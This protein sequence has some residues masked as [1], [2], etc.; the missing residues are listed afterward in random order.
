MDPRT[1][2]P[3]IGILA[4]EDSWYFQDLQCAASGKAH[5]ERLEFSALQSR[6][7][8]VESISTDALLSENFDAVIVR[9]MPP[10]SLEQVVFR[11]DALAGL[12]RQ[13]VLVINPPKSM[14]LAIDKYLSLSKLSSAGFRV[15]QTHVCQT[16]QDAMVAFEEMGPSVVVKPIFG[17]EGRGIMRVEDADLAH[18]VFK[19]LQQ[20]GQIIYLQKFVPHPGYDLRVMVLG[21]TM[22]GMRR[23]SADSWRTNLSRGAHATPET[24]PAEVAEVALAAVKTLDLAI[25]GLDFLPDGEGGWYLLEANAV[26]GW[27]GLSAA[28][29]VDIASKLMDYVVAKIA[30]R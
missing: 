17:G 9:T 21:D 29:D 4:N 12:E 6:I 24:V 20:M 1:Q 26:P 28:C 23:T 5:V 3:R 2:L 8:V 14:E 7:G 30:E 16:W 18:R 27:K 10:G 19:T 13:G 11:M 15:P 25:A 22:W